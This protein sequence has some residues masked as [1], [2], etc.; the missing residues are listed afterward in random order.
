MVE[1]RFRRVFRQPW[2]RIAV[3]AAGERRETPKTRRRAERRV[4]DAHRKD[5]DCHRSDPVEGYL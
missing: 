2:R 5:A 1:E 3:V 4:W